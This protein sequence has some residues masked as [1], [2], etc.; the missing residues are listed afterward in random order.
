M[1]YTDV[2]KILDGSDEQVL[3]R[4]S[5][6]ISHFKLMEELAI[7][8]KNKRMKQGY[9]NLDVPESKIVLDNVTGKCI[10]VKKYE[11]SFAN[12]IIEQF[13]LTANET[14]AERFYWLEVPFIYRVHEEP[15]FD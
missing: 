11:T 9:L 10:D 4:Y 3:K 15:D 8:L 6:Y 14:V 13:M 12:E 1:S 5:K 7:I 2:Q